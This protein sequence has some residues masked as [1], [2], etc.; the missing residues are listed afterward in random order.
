MSICVCHLLPFGHECYYCKW[1][2]TEGERAAEVQAGIERTVQ[3]GRE[4]ARRNELEQ[5]RVK[6]HKGKGRKR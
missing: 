4:S 1:P 2:K 3:Q 6:I 5:A